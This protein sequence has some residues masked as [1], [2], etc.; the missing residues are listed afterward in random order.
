MNALCSQQP[1]WQATF[2]SCRVAKLRPFDTLLAVVRDA[3][4]EQ[5][6]IV[7]E[8]HAVLCF[9]PLYDLGYRID[10]ILRDPAAPR[11]VW[12]DSVGDWG[13][14]IEVPL[15]RSTVRWEGS[16]VAWFRSRHCQ[17]ATLMDRGAG[18]P[19]ARI[20]SSGFATVS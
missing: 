8:L 17:G 11:R 7:G 10:F 1:D 9:H 13:Y 3:P 20:S 12:L 14:G 4:S 15:R 5:G 16:S 19:P 2:R 18:F 6:H